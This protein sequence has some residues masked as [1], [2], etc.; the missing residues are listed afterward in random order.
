MNFYVFLSAQV[1]CSDDYSTVDLIF[2]LEKS[3]LLRTPTFVLEITTGVTVALMAYERYIA[4]CQPFDYET[5]LS[6][7]KRKSIYFILVMFYAMQ[8]FLYGMNYFLISVV[9]G[10]QT[11]RFSQKNL[12]KF[13]KLKTVK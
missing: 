1:S 5:I 11:R 8:L 2:N 12:A 9:R 3:K 7:P 13:P 4:I 10:N 6:N